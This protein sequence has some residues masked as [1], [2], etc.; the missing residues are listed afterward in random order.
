MTLVLVCPMG[1]R[2]ELENVD[3]ELRRAIERCVHKHVAACDVCKKKI[4][5]IEM[6]S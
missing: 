2:R 5:R 6:P 3:E 4:E 1:H